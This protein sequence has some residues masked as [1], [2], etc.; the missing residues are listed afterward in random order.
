MGQP[1]CE[2]TS[3]YCNASCHASSVLGTYRGI[4]IGQNYSRG[5][6]DF[7]FYPDGVVAFGMAN[8]R[9]KY[10]A[11][12]RTTG[13]ATE[14]APLTLLFTEAPPAGPLNIQRECLTERWK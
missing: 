4:L 5:E 9:L 6:W 13:P 2:Y 14:G 11:K 12:Y 8:S 3:D 1:G 7:T 10:E